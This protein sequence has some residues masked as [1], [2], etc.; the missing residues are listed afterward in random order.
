MGAN[1]VNTVLNAKVVR[2]VNIVKKQSIVLI[3]LDA[4][5]FTIAVIATAVTNVIIVKIVIYALNVKAVIKRLTVINV[6]SV[7]SVMVS[8]NAV[9][10]RDV[11]DVL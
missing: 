2:I 11:H 8:T 7:H 5:L 3:H 4:G 10:V 6:N 9:S 1:I